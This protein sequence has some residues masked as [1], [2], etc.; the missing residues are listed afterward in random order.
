MKE[1]LRERVLGRVTA[2]DVLKPG[3]ADILVPRS[4]AERRRMTC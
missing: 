3:T 4:T 2:E 1:P